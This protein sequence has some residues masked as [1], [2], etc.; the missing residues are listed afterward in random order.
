MKSALEFR[1]L[2]LLVF[3]VWFSY[4]EFIEQSCLSGAGRFL[5]EHG[6]QSPAVVRT[7]PGCMAAMVLTEQQRSISLATIFAEINAVLGREG[8]RL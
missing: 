1:N 2:F 7:L 6:Y 5:R 4:R 8:Y 3:V